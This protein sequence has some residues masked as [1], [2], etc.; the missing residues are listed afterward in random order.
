MLRSKIV[1][2]SLV[3]YDE[4]QHRWIEAF[5][6]KVHKYLT[7]FNDLDVDDQTGDP[8]EYTFTPVENGASSS[9][10]TLKDAQ[11]GWLRLQADTFDNDGGNLQLKGESF[12]L[13]A[14]DPIYFGTSILLDVADQ[15]DFCVGLCITNTALVG[16]MTDGVYFRKVDGSTSVSFVSEK[17][18]SEEETT[19]VHT[20]VAATAVT[21][22]F[23]T[24]GTSHIWAYVNGVLAAT[25]ATTIPDDEE[26]R[27]SVAYIN[28]TAQT[29]KGIEV[30]YIRAIQIMNG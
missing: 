9:T 24:D 7:D 13:T 1:N 26:L 8:T 6:L 5:G 15:S 29:S 21:L 11:G 4:Y 10:V 28:G 16:G 3:F 2:N 19:A 22:E 23:L 27:V 20:L 25:H 12:K 30:D 14:G 18:S 17:D